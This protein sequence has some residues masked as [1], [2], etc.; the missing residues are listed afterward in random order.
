MKWFECVPNF[1]EGRDADRVERIVAPARTMPG[2]AVLDVERN[3]DHN[4]CVVSLAGSADGLVEALLKMMA[5]ALKEI[6]LNQHR[7]EHPRMGAVDVVPFIPLG[8]ATMEDAIGLAEHL[9]ERAWKELHLP[10]YLYAEAARRPE[11][12]DLG[13]V[14]EGE[15]E[16]IRSSIGSEPGRA[17]DYG[18]KAVHPTG[19]I[20]AIGARPVL[21]AF[22]VY[23]GTSDVS[24]A[25]KVARAA[26]ARDG[27]LSEVKALGF[28]I[29]ERHRAQVSMNL[30]DYRRTPVHRAIELVRR[31]AERY[32]VAVEESEIVGLIP[33]DALFDAAEYFLQ[34]NEFN[35][36]N[37]LERRLRV[38]APP[39]PPPTAFAEMALPE[40]TRRLAMRTPTP[41]G[42]SAAAATASIGAAL[43]AMVFAYSM[44][45]AGPTGPLA[46]PLQELN[47]ER[48]ALLTFMDK[49]AESYDA[50]RQARKGLKANPNDP[51]AQ[52]HWLDAVRRA[53]EVPL[54]AAR[55]AAK[56]IRLLETH[57]AATNPAVGSDLVTALALL[58]AAREGALANVATNVEDLKKAGRPVTDLLNEV[59]H[60]RSSPP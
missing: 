17:P 31:E 12:R 49:D 54:E 1:S 15:F 44:P 59:E 9:G 41:G 42:G 2:V 26:R 4:R 51:A 11:R 27:G 22:N 20:V 43:G 58:R 36:A 19:G 18:D 28:E 39:A 21:V 45:A 10:V 52:Q 35:R 46:A 14:R 55:H 7:G 48:L 57:K 6:D 32:G 23:L 8:D 30:T 13:V 24:V 53:A 38:A 16:G 5:V 3:A 34:L 25:K 50:V 33:E 40:F 37:V 29:K 47:E 60:L 56:L